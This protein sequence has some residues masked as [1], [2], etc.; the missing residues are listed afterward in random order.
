MRLRLIVVVCG[1][2]AAT[3]LG[4]TF[5][6]HTSAERR[7]AEDTTLR[8]LQSASRSLSEHAAHVLGEAALVLRAARD[9]LP[10]QSLVGEA[11][12]ATVRRLLRERLDG[13]TALS[14]ILIA[15]PD[16]KIVHAARDA[17]AVGTTL[18]EPVLHSA[19]ARKDGW[20]TISLP[21]RI[22]AS[23][24]P[25]MAVSLL[26]TDGGGQPVGIVSATIQAAGFDATY[27]AVV[28]EARSTIALWRRD[29]AMLAQY[30]ADNHRADR[31]VQWGPPFADALARSDTGSFREILVDGGTRTTV[32]RTLKDWPLIV[33]ASALDADYL[34]AWRNSTWWKGIGAAV[35]IALVLGATALLA[36]HVER[37]RLAQA[38]A[39][40]NRQHL[41]D[42]IDSLP[43]AFILFDK[44]DHLVAANRKYREYF[45]NVAHLL[46]AGTTY[47]QI[48]RPG[49]E[50]GAYPDAVGREEEWLAQRLRA[51]RQPGPPFEQALAD[52][53]WYRISEH[54]TAD[55]G[56]VGVRVDITE[57][58]RDERRLQESE[59]HAQAI[60]DATVDG[61]V[62]IDEDGTIERVNRSATSMFGYGSDEL[63][64]RNV[65]LLMAEPFRSRHDLYLARY[66]ETSIARVIGGGGI[67]VSGERKDGTTFPID[68]VIGELMLDGRRRFIGAIRDLSDRV[69]IQAMLT[70]AI[71]STSDGFVYFDPDGKLVLCNQKYIEAY[72]YLK[73]VPN[74]QGTT[75]EQIIRG[76]VEKNYVVD[77]L[78]RSDPEAWVQ[79][80][81]QQF[82]SPPEE[83]QLHQLSDGRWLMVSDQRTPSGGLV[84]V[85]TDVTERIS[86]ELALRESERRFR[87]LV[88]GARDYAIIM[89]DP[90]GNVT[91]WNEGARQ[92][93]GYE[94]DD[95]IGQSHRAF[96][97]PPRIKVGAP[98]AALRTARESGRYA[99]REQRARKD[100]SLFWAD[101]VISRI[102][103]DSDGVPP[104]FASIMRD[105]TDRI[106]IEE[107]LAHAQ[108][109]EAV[110]QLT[111]GL[112]HDFNNLLQ[113]VMTNLEFVLDRS[114]DDD[115][116][117]R[118]G[119]ALRA[120]ER[121]AEL[122]S[123]MLAFARRQTLSPRRTDVH[124]LIEE[125][126][127]LLRR[128][129]GENIAID[130]RLAPALRSVMI[131]RGQLENAILNLALNA[132]DA[133]PQGGRLRIAADNLDFDDAYIRQ[134]PEARRGRY[135]AISIADTGTGM[136]DDVRAHAFEP[137]FTTKEIGKGSGLGLSMVYGFVKQSGGHIQLDSAPGRG[138]TL[139]LYLPEAPTVSVG[140]G[141]KVSSE[142]VSR[143]LG[144][145]VLV[146]EDNHDV[147]RLA[148][149]MLDGLGYRVIEAADGPAALAVLD[150]SAEIKLLLTDVMLAGGMSGPDVA[151]VARTRR[152]EVKLAYMSGYAGDA[153]GQVTLDPDVTFITKPFTRTGFAR[154]IRTA[155]DA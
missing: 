90:D 89:L 17:A 7:Q 72:S 103:S 47:E 26:L 36:R 132:R 98:A 97:P 38:E 135:V 18:S 124:A 6:L 4:L 3:V 96:W 9:F 39:A 75:F 114:D 53:R 94:A 14:D 65:K 78:A 19:L 46:T 77:P 42:A 66:R 50:S 13:A 125:L 146:V 84:G 37:L 100:G 1:V 41:A 45:R 67:E 137:F 139:T 142:P 131:D 22:G 136:P 112:A 148:V 113:V 25:V 95:I 104:G 24:V 82:H 62:V 126:A 108:K 58:K 52:G 35:G 102:D 60:M 80:R 29:G 107:Q 143:G 57:R 141:I 85:R 129:L 61:L 81:L 111:G 119:D 63:I 120:A 30:P 88:D 43:D 64:G 74:L 105:V 121:G 2:L 106:A 134:H 86:F 69:N 59:R 153:G 68:L 133:M 117:I 27:R 21:Q 93:T 12:D 152:P 115:V 55:G 33:S 147:R 92:I 76:C 31:T 118:A 54:A 123:Q 149:T 87:L 71:E 73:D 155:L 110:G 32:Y 28:D 16:G 44:N 34:A 122:T 140:T 23:E 151:R 49:L 127:G 145:T 130:L 91:S 101:V 10:S 154:A 144:E 99:G 150:A 83:P 79:A 51:H 138:T 56:I 8:R 20:P 11:G 5:L 40:V 128:T 48:L 109:M 15:R 116:S 70:E